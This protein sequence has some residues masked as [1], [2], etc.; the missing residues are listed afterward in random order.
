MA[1]PVAVVEPILILDSALM[2]EFSCLPPLLQL[3]LDPY[4]QPLELLIR[5]TGH[6]RES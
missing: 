6:I 2:A 4:L 3:G 5:H 1:L